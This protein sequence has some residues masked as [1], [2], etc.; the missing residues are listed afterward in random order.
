[1]WN[2]VAPLPPEDW[3]E[4]IELYILGPKIMW[5]VMDYQII[6]KNYQGQEQQCWTESATLHLT[7][8]LASHSPT[9]GPHY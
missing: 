3:M 8:H 5:S 7:R 4:T 6:I 1:M 9:E 2:L